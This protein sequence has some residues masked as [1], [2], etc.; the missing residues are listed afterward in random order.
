MFILGS[1]LVS[2]CSKKKI[3]ASRLPELEIGV[4]LELITGLALVIIGALAISRGR[5]SISLSGSVT[6]LVL[7]S[8]NLTAALVGGSALIAIEACARMK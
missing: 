8:L 3:D 1:Y 4:F 6:M 7:G 2:T 5:P